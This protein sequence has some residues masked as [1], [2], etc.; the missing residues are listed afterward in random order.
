MLAL[1]SPVL[2]AKHRGSISAEHGL[3]FKK[4]PFI[5]Y[6]KP[7]EAVKLMKDIKKV[8]DPKVCLHYIGTDHLFIPSWWLKITSSPR[9]RDNIY[10]VT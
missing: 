9:A 6:S 8:F 2:P 3:G 5:H 10:Y 7:P 4:A 1:F